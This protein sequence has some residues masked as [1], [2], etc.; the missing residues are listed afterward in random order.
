MINIKPTIYQKL[1]EVTDNVSDVYPQDWEKFPIVIYL[2]EENKPYEYTD[3][4][5]QKSFLRYKV[6]IF[7]KDSTSEL[8]VKVN[9]VFESVG[10]RRTSS[11][12]LADSYLRHKV[13]RFEGVLDLK[14]RI[15][16]QSRMEG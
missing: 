15:V 11:I 12:D 3:D 1:K 8:A 13:M 2:E 5:E 4:K 7:D 10:L 9:D 14:S 6:D 16:Y